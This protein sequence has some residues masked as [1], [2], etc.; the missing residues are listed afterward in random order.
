MTIH[1]QIAGTIPAAVARSHATSPIR[2]ARLGARNWK[3]RWHA[4]TALLA[5]SL[6][7][8]EPKADD[9]QDTCEALAV[10]EISSDLVAANLDTEVAGVCRSRFDYYAPAE[11]RNNDAMRHCAFAERDSAFS[12]SALEG[13]M[14]LAMIYANGIGVP[15]NLPLARAFICEVRESLI[16]EDLPVLLQQIDA[17]EKDPG[18][19]SPLDVCSS[20][21]LGEKTLA[22]YEDGWSRD[23]ACRNFKVELSDQNGQRALA[24]DQASWSAAARKQYAENVVPATKAFIDA[25]LQYEWD[26]T[27]AEAL[28]MAQYHYIHLNSAHYYG[29]VAEFQSGKIPAASGRDVAMAEAR[30]RTL[31]DSLRSAADAKKEEGKDEEDE[32]EGIRVVGSVT[33]TGIEKVQSAWESYRK[34]WLAFAARQYPKIGRHAVDA[35]LIGMR[36]DMLEELTRYRALP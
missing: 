15:R 26:E 30:L 24:R 2:H 7:S 31:L 14:I 16:P 17:I 18:S 22:D 21:P 3:L 23:R 27:K 4:I 32:E 34:A 25:A 29:V 33:Y 10:F 1:K 9:A 8:T 13:S 5:F 19:A 36:L 20:F 12:S 6:V 35:H 11:A 28:V